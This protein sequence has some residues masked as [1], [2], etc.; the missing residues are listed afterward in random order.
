MKRWL[1]W[2]RLALME[3]RNSL[4]GCVAYSVVMLLLEGNDMTIHSFTAYAM[5]FF[6]I[7]WLLFACTLS[8]TR[9]TLIPDVM[10]S[11]G[12][13]RKNVWLC[14]NL[15]NLTNLVIVVAIANIAAIVN[16]G[17]IVSHFVALASV[18]AIYLFTSGM[19]LNFYCIQKNTGSTQKSILHT[20][21]LILTILLTMVAITFTGVIN[22]ASVETFA[23]TRKVQL[24]STCIV[25]AIGIVIYIIGNLQVRKKLFTC[26]VGL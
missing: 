22:P 20:V 26:E 14:M 25:G 11:M 24:I 8:V 1:Y 10:I 19:G 18:P 21:L 4:L 23:D 7:I 9:F 16:D 2:I 3:L 12:E 17:Q 13:T 15:Y 6:L 5:R